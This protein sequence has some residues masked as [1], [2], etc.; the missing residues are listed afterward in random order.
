LENAN[1]IPEAAA[2]SMTI[3]GGKA[4]FRNNYAGNSKMAMMKTKA[5]EKFRKRDGS[6]WGGFN[7]TKII[8]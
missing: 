2:P 3:A 5:A 8:T 4:N 7:D 1:T 6:N